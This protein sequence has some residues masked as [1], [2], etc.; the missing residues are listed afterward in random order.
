MSPTL[1]A[2]SAMTEADLD[3]VLQIERQGHQRPWTEKI[4]REEL[5]REWARLVVVRSPS[6]VAF[7][8][9][10]LVHDEL[11]LLNIVTDQRARRRGHARMLMEHIVTQAQT[12]KCRVV[13]L[14]VRK[15]NQAAIGMY[16]CFG[17]SS[18][19]LRPKYY[20]DNQED[21]LIMLLET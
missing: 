20:A 4:F 7:C 21:A 2:I 15:S 11:H 13:T 6:L 3:E 17:F 12:Q 19:G 18:V 9:Y 10:W 5:A 14:E 16:E 1:P 8:N